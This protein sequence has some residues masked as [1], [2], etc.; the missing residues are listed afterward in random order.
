MALIEINNS[1]KVFKR[2][3]LSIRSLAWILLVFL[4]SAFIVFEIS[5]EIIGGSKNLFMDF[6][7]AGFLVLLVLI[8]AA[9]TALDSLLSIFKPEL[10]LS[11]RLVRRSLR[12]STILFTPALYLTIVYITNLV[13]V[14]VVKNLVHKVTNSTTPMAPSKFEWDTP[15]QIACY[16]LYSIFFIS[17]LITTAIAL[18]KSK[19]KYNNRLICIPFI[20]VFP[21]Y[22]ERQ[23]DGEIC[24]VQCS[25]EIIAPAILSI[26]PNAIASMILGASI[27]FFYARVRKINI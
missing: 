23:I 11:I 26:H 7:F 3:I 6:N 17:V 4:P 27:A 18:S 15:L 9:L 20:L 12:T 22:I 10:I 8:L 14:K 2:T 13:S 1:L 21:A 24:P 5:R 16:C 19:D 25:Y